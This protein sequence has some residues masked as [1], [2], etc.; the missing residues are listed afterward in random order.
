[1]YAGG[2]PLFDERTGERTE[3]LAFVYG[4]HAAARAA[5]GSPDGKSAPKAPRKGGPQAQ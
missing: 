3:R 1:M 2:S 4:R 5:C